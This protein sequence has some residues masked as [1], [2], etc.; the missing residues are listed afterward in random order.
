MPGRLMLPSSL[1]SLARIFASAMAG[2]GTGPP[3][4][5][6][7][8][9]C[10]SPITSTCTVTRPRRAVVIDGRP[11][12]KFA[13]SVSTIASACSRSRCFL[14]NAGSDP[15][16]DS[17]SPSTI[18]FTLTGRDPCAFSQESIAAMCTRMPALSSAAPRE[19]PAIPLH[20]L[21]RIRLAPLLLLAG[22]LHVVVRIEEQGRAA[23]GLGPLSVRVGVGAGH[24]QHLHVLQALAAH[25]VAG[26]LRA[27][28]HLLPVESVEGDAGDPDQLLQLLQVFSLVG[29]VVGE[30][31]LDRLVVDGGRGGHGG[32]P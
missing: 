20:G 28:A 7:C 6:L 26:A 8:T 32:G 3:H 24:L 12:S 19:E 17:S 2:S 25:Q 16:P 23:L 4:M 30:R 9:G 18:I 11:V 14:R 13:V 15:E 27:T 10:F 31:L 22:G 5:P 21:E 29:G 1:T